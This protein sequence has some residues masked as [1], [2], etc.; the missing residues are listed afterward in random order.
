VDVAVV[1]GAA[2]FLPP[3]WWSA[4]YVGGVVVLLSF[5][6]R[7]HARLDPRVGADVP[8]LV[9]SVAVPLLVLGPWIAHTWA[10]SS[11]L[12]W[13]PVLVLLLCG[14]RVASYALLRLAR[15]RG[16]LVE[17]TLILGAGQVG[18]SLSRT[19]CSKPHYGLRPLGFLEDNPY[20]ELPLPV[21][22]TTDKLGRILRH[23]GA[24]RVIVAYGSARDANMVSVLRACDDA[25]VVVYV[26][27]RFFELGLTAHVAGVDEVR[28][29]PVVRLRRTALRRSSR[30]IKRGFDLVVASLALAA[31]AP[32]LAVV[33]AAVRIS[34]D[35]P[36]LF[37]QRRIGRA[38]QPFD[39]LKFRSMKVNSDS[40]TTWDVK[41]DARVTPVGALLRRTSLDEL[42]QLWNVLRGDMSM[43]GPRPERPHF[44]QIFGDS[45]R[46]Y[47][48]RHRV[49]VGLTG[50]SQ[51]H[52]LRGDTS[53]EERAAFDNYYVEHW[54]VW[55]DIRIILRTLG[56]ILKHDPDQ[57]AGAAP[58]PSVSAVAS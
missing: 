9:R 43:V 48:D 49:A 17:D 11:I 35:G 44:V 19:F 40:D 23:T 18:Q 46:G 1:A 22:G 10:G 15:T 21:L 8:R 5:G 4:I 53:I 57:P 24:R 52:G 30:L 50:W 2:V 38:G 51:I 32:V 39:L 7:D 6:T 36:I 25:K 41:R 26:L 20:D 42:P 29:M 33:A 58:P 56:A 16:W 14:G 28:G 45:V 31:T 37:R 54:S 13:S 34:S 3:T 12:R 47:H 27:P 55:L